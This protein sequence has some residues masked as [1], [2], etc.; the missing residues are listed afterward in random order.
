MKIEHRLFGRSLIVI[1]IL[2]FAYIVWNI[3]SEYRK[4]DAKK[5]LTEDQL[6]KP[7][8]KDNYSAEIG[9]TDLKSAKVLEYV[10]LV[11]VKT[12]DLQRFDP[13]TYTDD[14]QM[15]A[16]GIEQIQ[17]W[18]EIYEEGF[19]YPLLEDQQ[20]K[21]QAF[22]K[23]IIREQK[24]ALQVYRD[25]Y[26]PAMRKVLW[27]LD[28]TAKTIGP[29]FT[30]VEFVAGMFAAN[31]NIKTFQE[32]LRETLHKLR[33]K[34]ATYKWYPEQREYTAYNMNTLSD[35]AL[36]VWLPGGKYREVK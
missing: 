12:E 31:K 30:T 10:R 22:R 4:S 26:G 1:L 17:S 3:G 13:K 6:A 33:F 2:C 35:D 8:E 29:G 18:I 36:V 9:S 32:E 5:E 21:H 19:Y 15:L 23:A 16:L 7:K 25:A 20:Q 14:V 34:K 28:A 24:Q 11:V 27:E